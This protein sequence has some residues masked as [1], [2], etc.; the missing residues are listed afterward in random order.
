MVRVMWK[1]GDYIRPY[2]HNHIVIK[3]SSVK[4]ISK[5]SE[6]V[7]VILLVHSVACFNKIGK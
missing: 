2:I 6:E 4:Q 5:K 7:A 1:Q 3:H